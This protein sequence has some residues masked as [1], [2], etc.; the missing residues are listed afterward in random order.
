M[1]PLSF[2]YKISP[3]VDQ[4]RADTLVAEIRSFNQGKHSLLWEMPCR[5]VE[6]LQFY[7][8]DPN[9]KLIAGIM[10]RTNQIPEWLEVTVIWVAESRRHQGLGRELMRLAEDE[11]KARG[12]VFAR[13]ATS[14]Y[15]A[16]DFY[17]KLDY[18][19]YGMLEN[20]PRGE[21]CYYF[22]KE[23]H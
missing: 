4:T 3:E 14:E 6:P 8:L 22:W 13:L 7:I 10:G 21:T 15:Q 18:Q 9:E 1:E 20:C 19:Q 11:A 2:P 17:R 5:S 23:L 16:P 12:C